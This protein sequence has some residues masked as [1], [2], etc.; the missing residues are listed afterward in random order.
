MAKKKVLIVHNKYRNLGG[1]DLAVENE[2]VFLK[3]H[4][5]VEVL[6]FT[7]NVLIVKQILNFI[8]NK[9]FFAERKILKKVHDFK[10][11]IVYFHNTWFNIWNNI[12]IRLGKKTNI[13]I[14]LKLHNYRFDCTK[15]YSAKS[16][17]HNSKVCMGCGGESKSKQYFNKYFDNSYIKSFLVNYYGKRYYNILKNENIKILNLTN[18]QREFMINQGFNKQRLFVFPNLIKLENFQEIKCSDYVLYAGRIS[19][20]KG[21]SELIDIFSSVKTNYKLLIIGDGPEA[22]NLKI[23]KNKNIKFLG[24]LNHHKTLSYINSAKAVITNTKLYEGQPTLLCEA[25]LLS[26]PSIF[27]DNGGIK[28]FFPKDYQLKFNH[29]NTNS[30]RNILKNLD[31]FDLIAL[32]KQNFTF[33]KKI[34]N[35]EKLS[36]KFMDIYNNG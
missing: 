23:Q 13:Q 26:V 25:S 14:F 9:N 4:F 5:N 10:P 1:E 29:N 27:P 20:E 2:I 6:Y 16:H 31:S 36:K 8:S 12:F 17:F 11:E 22:N 19:N 3:E 35:N 15:T 21:V 28:E 7:N 30:L 32:G 33:T 18:F 34:L 24:E